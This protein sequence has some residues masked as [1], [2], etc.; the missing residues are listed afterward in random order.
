MATV[1]KVPKTAD[2]SIFP[3]KGAS[4]AAVQELTR[5]G[6]ASFGKKCASFKDPVA[7]DGSILLTVGGPTYMALVEIDASD[8]GRASQASY[9]DASGE[10][11]KSVKET[12]DCKS[13]SI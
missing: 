10:F 7:P 12:F 13:R 9:V 3:P 6:V 1:A 4:D 5:L 2:W 11:M 8:L